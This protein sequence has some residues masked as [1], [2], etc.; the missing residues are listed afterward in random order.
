[1]E[2]VK[3]NSFYIANSSYFGKQRAAPLQF[4]RTG[5]TERIVIWLIRIFFISKLHLFRFITLPPMA[6][7][8]ELLYTVTLSSKYPCR[9][10]ETNIWSFWPK[11][12]K[13]T[14]LSF[15]NSLKIPCC[16]LFLGFA[17]SKSLLGAKTISEKK[18]R[19]KNSR[20]RK[21]SRRIK[22]VLLQKTTWLLIWL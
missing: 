4:I 3:E 12:F 5:N 14:P 19:R 1:M 8:V 7:G 13:T 6:W 2:P 21:T 15:R 11:V 18:K 17:A 20:D 16:N 10:Q 9:K 22:W